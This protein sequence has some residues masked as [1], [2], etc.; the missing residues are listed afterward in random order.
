MKR[1]ILTLLII[2]PFVAQAQSITLDKGFWRINLCDD[3]GERLSLEKMEELSSY[4]FDVRRY[5]RL[6]NWSIVGHLLLGVGGTTVL[7]A[8][9]YNNI[10]GDD[11]MYNKTYYNKRSVIVGSIGVLTALT[12]YLVENSCKKMICKEVEALNSKIQI[13]IAYNFMGVK[14]VF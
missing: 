11:S 5:N 7:Y 14:I 4:G 2:I 13:G 3:S 6:N 12:G 8:G 10:H 1:I 9:V